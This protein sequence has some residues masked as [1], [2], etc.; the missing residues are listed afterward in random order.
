MHTEPQKEHQWLKK[1]VGNWVSETDCKMGP[2]APPSKMKGTDKG[3]MLGDL[4]AI[5]D[6]TLEMPDGDPATT[7]MTLGYDPQKKRFVGTWIGSMM[8]TLWVYDGKLDDSGNILTLSAE[9]PHM[10]EPGKL[11]Q[12]RDII[13]F[14]NDDHRILT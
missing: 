6:G 11:A 9:G 2:D 4:W 10:G 8:A 5:C 13:E 12:Y 1:L 7:V 3:R 14:K